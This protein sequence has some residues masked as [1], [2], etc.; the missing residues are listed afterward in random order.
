M[1]EVL[2]AKEIL[3]KDY[4][5]AADVWSVTSYK[6]VR[7]DALDIERWNMLNPTKKQKT[8]YI[9]DLFKDNDG[10]FVAATDYLK[11][12][13]DSIAKWLPKHLVSLGTDGFGRSESRA[14]LRDFFEI[15]AKHIVFAALGELAR[16]GKIKSENDT[17]Q[18]VQ[19]HT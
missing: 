13:P 8:S 18:H 6:E 16:E 7:R 3:E 1:N 2:K 17:R 12:L 4:S 10:V 14:A 5:V 9:K 15:D 19:N 11:A